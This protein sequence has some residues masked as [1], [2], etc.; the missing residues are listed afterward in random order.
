MERGGDCVER[1]RSER[2]KVAS[3]AEWKPP[4]SPESHTHD[5]RH[6]RDIVDVARIQALLERYG[7]R[8]LARVYTEAEAAYAMGGA[9]RAERWREVRG[10]GSGDEGSR[11]GNRR[12][13]L[14][15]RGDAARAPG[16][17]RGPSAREA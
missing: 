6:R 10:E 4:A 3:V 13:P 8:F 11:T 15:G 17:A 9:N 5:R 14:E 7:E 1:N 16:K 2:S 12:D